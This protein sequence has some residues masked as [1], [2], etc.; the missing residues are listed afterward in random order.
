MV[1]KG[2]HTPAKDAAESRFIPAP[3]KPSKSNKQQPVRSAVF[4]I[5]VEGAQ[6]W[7]DGKLHDFLKSTTFN[8]AVGYPISNEGAHKQIRDTC[9]DNGTAFDAVDQNPLEFNSREDLFSNN[10]GAIDGFGG[11]GGGDEFDTGEVDLQ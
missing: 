6:A 11:L 7:Q 9:L 4:D 8:P 5:L 3:Q 1:N 2:M 10:D